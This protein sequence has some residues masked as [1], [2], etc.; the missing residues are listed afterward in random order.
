MYELGWLGQTAEYGRMDK[1][2]LGYPGLTLACCPV[3]FG[4]QV[5]R[6]TVNLHPPPC[7]D[8]PIHGLGD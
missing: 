6:H 4:K 8:F 2:R 1:K 7:P 3:D 5:E